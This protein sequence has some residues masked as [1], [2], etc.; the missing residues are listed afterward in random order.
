[1]A[2]IEYHIKELTSNDI[3]SDHPNDINIVL[4]KH[5][6]VLLQKCKTFES[7]SLELPDNSGTIKTKIGII[8]DSVGSGKSYVIL[9]LVKEKDDMI[10]TNSNIRSYGNN[11]LFIL[12][13]DNCLIQLKTNM[14]VIPHTILSQWQQYVETFGGKLKM[15]FV[16]RL[17][18][19]R[20][21]EKENVDDID[22]II[23]TNTY[24]HHIANFI[25][26]Q[27]FK[28]KR[29][30]FDEVDNLNIPS[31][32]E[33]ESSFYWFV[34]ASYNNLVYPNGLN[35]RT[36]NNYID[37]ANG[38]KNSGFIKDMFVNI[39]QAPSKYIYLLILK[40]ND[41][42][43]KES[44]HLPEIYFKNVLCKS[45]ISLS[46]LNGIVDSN[47]IEHLNAGDTD[48]AIQHISA[49]NRSS[50]DNII[51]MCISKFEIERKNFE[52][53]LAYVQQIEINSNEQRE[54]E[55]MRLNSRIKETQH[56]IDSIRKR[57]KETSSCY[58][59]YDDISHKTIL[60]CCSNAVCFKCINV[61]LTQ[62]PNC[63]LCKTV[64]TSDDMYVI[65]K[66]TTQLI[67]FSCQI[68]ES[69]DKFTN[70]I[71]IINSRNSD[72]KILIFSG[73]DNTFSKIIQRLLNHKV[74]FDFL[75]GNQYVLN[76]TIHDF[77]NGN[78]QILLINPRYYG[79][80]LNLP[81][82]TDIIM[83]HKFDT[84]IHKQVIGRAQRFGRTTNL[85]VWYLLH[86]TE[87]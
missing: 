3:A 21:L 85:N 23:V 63:P 59:C 41:D 27:K 54:M 18:H 66:D 50:E 31:C 69:N 57:I 42:F 49:F 8:G 26:K 74:K 56:K 44:F 5:Q 53:K 55:I 86:E 7:K 79:S 6:L 58:I 75:K 48:G 15:F 20:N 71:N 14:L 40:N 62:N 12:K 67:D 65:C 38:I 34:T 70:L 22:L 25:R 19:I 10:D 16:N 1:M 35:I 24:Y 46:I 64:T 17:I 84:E 37:I 60:K 43:V 29:V 76:K 9:S 4:K 33:I 77:A 13:P 73:H 39:S 45:P 51:G 87:L 81:M 32:P 36:E 11:K 2:E 68:H 83:F 47:I 30:F 82:T 61:W 52:A 72:S 78:T 28:L 80:G